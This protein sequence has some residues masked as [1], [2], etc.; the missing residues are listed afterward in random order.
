MTHLHLCYLWSFGVKSRPFVILAWTIWPSLKCISLTCLWCCF[1]RVHHLSI[2]FLTS[3]RNLFSTT[4]IIAVKA[5]IE[6]PWS[7]M[8]DGHTKNSGGT[9]WWI[10]SDANL[11]LWRARK[12]KVNALLP[13]ENKSTSSIQDSTPLVESDSAGSINKDPPMQF[14]P[15]FTSLQAQNIVSWS[16][17]KSVLGWVRCH[18]IWLGCKKSATNIL[19]FNTAS[20]SW[21][22]FMI[23]CL[24]WWC[25]KRSVKCRLV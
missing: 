6:D 1:V 3:Q 19:V 16:T 21:C 24:T 10:A 11:A 17:V 20:G 8:Q 18:Q 13:T 22:L 12:D 25:E 5:C 9:P 7:I 14:R 15:L 4:C 23:W 2:E